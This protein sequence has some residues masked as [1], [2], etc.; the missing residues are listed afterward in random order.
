MNLVFLSFFL[1]SSTVFWIGSLI[2]DRH[3]R[4]QLLR[5]TGFAEETYLLNNTELLPNLY[6]CYEG[7][8]GVYWRMKGW[9]CSR[10]GHEEWCLQRVLIIRHMFSFRGL[11]QGYIFRAMQILFDAFVWIYWPD[12]V[13]INV[14]LK[15]DNNRKVIT[16]YI[17]LMEW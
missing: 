5:C 14:S 9:M 4:W 6:G 16:R 3:E 13:W 17:Y 8:G 12:H 11:N 1:F 15:A 7:I 2:S 10:A